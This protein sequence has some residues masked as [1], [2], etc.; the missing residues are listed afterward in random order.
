MNALRQ[1]GVQFHI[2][3]F[4]TGYSSMSYLKRLPVNAIKIDQ[5]FVRDML[6]KPADTAIVEAMLAVA[7][8]FGLE[9]IAEGVETAEQLHRLHALGCLIFQGFYFSRPVS[10]ADFARKYLTSTS[11]Q[12]HITARA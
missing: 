12:P 6:A 7:H 2:D 8:S 1:L 11:G 9:V 4:G 5:S 10:A 3:D